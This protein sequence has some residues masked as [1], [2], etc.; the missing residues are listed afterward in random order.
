MRANVDGAVVGK[1]AVFGNQD[2]FAD[3]DVVTV[4][5]IE[6]GF[7]HGTGAKGAGRRAVSGLGGSFG[8][9]RDQYLLQELSPLADANPVER[10]TGIDESPEGGLATLAV[11]EELRIERT[12][13]FSTEHLALFCFPR[14]FKGHVLLHVESQAGLGWVIAWIHARRVIWIRVW[15]GIGIGPVLDVVLENGYTRLRVRI[16]R[17]HFAGRRVNNMVFGFG[18]LWTGSLV[19]IIIIVVVVA[20]V[21]VIVVGD[22]SSLSE[23]WLGRVFGHVLRGGRLPRAVLPCDSGNSAAGACDVLWSNALTVVYRYRPG[24]GTV[25]V[26]KVRRSGLVSLLRCDILNVGVCRFRVMV[27]GLEGD[28]ALWMR[29]LDTPAAPNGVAFARKTTTDTIITWTMGLGGYIDKRKKNWGDTHKT[30]VVRRT[31]SFFFCRSCSR[32]LSCC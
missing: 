13:L 9:G 31:F 27:F 6:W 2:I 28:G 15:V 32:S 22:W 3:V 16:V 29:R 10:V 14:L 11:A 26:Y 4:V 17:R 19:I 12:V 24:F 25:G 30:G 8:G 1:E 5:A 7:Y 20:A 23:F 18:L 21:V